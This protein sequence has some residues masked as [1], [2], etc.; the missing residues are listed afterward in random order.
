MRENWKG[1]LVCT[2]RHQCQFSW[3]C[4]GKSDGLDTDTFYDSYL[5]AQDVIM[6]KY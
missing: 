6:G 4:D 2:I 3:F 1:D 5:V